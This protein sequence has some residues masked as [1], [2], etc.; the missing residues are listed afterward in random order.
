MAER[1]GNEEEEQTKSAFIAIYPDI[2]KPEH[3]SFLG[4]AN[5][6]VGVE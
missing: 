2:M 6:L 3:Y 1:S 5:D 4:I